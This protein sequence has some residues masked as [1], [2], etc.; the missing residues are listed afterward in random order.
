M[1]DEKMKPLIRMIFIGITSVIFMMFL[2][3]GIITFS[4]G[5]ITIDTI[6]LPENLMLQ[7]LL[8]I[9]FGLADTHL[10]D[11]IF[12]KAAEV[13]NSDSNSKK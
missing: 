5:K 10:A 1:E 9:I 4:I 3:I 6:F 13:T 2:T 12:N 7:I 8:G 11:L